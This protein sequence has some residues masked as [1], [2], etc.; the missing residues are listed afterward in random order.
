MSDAGKVTGK[1]ATDGLIIVATHGGDYDIPVEVFSDQVAEMIW[2]GRIQSLRQLV[3]VVVEQREM[4]NHPRHYNE[5]PSK[6]EV[7]EIVELMNFNVGNGVK[8]VMRAEHKGE[9]TQDLKKALWYFKRQLET[10]FDVF[11]TSGSEIK[12]RRLLKKVVAHEA[13]GSIIWEVL[14]SVRTGNIE[15]AIRKIEITIG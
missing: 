7:I 14:T 6:V 9:R 13:P 10:P 15:D 11:L 8:Y 2:N 1:A 5:H 4:V 12:G 3:A